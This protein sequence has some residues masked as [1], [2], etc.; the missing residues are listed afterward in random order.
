MK[1]F[2]KIFPL[3]LAGVLVS[4]YVQPAVHAAYP[5]MQEP[6][7][8]KWGRLAVFE[9]GKRYPDYDI[10]DYLYMGRNLAQN[11][12]IVEKFKLWLKKGSTEKGV[13]ITIT[14]TPN[15]V[16]KTIAFQETDR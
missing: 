1:I 14:L 12:D 7:Y 8:A 2:L 13:I 6:A 16:F 3:L 11:E 10:V 5:G 4:S 9:T 15:G